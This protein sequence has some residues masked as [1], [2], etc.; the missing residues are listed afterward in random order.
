MGLPSVLVQREGQGVAG[1]GD[2]R[3]SSAPASTPVSVEE[4]GL[5][6]TDSQ[7]TLR[8]ADVEGQNPPACTTD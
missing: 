2:L 7:A 6:G 3:S 8:G 5:G 4:R 1:I